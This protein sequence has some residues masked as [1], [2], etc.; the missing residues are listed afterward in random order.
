MRVLEVPSYEKKRFGG[1]GKLRSF[2]DG[3]IIL[4]TIISNL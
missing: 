2:Q 3:F 1:E 4:R